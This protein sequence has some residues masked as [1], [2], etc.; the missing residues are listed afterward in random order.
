M[1]GIVQSTAWR[2]KESIL[3]IF[4]QYQVV[5]Y[6]CTSLPVLPLSAGESTGGDIGAF[7][8]GRRYSGEDLTVD[9]PSGTDVCDISTLTIWCEDFDAFFTRITIPA[10]TFVSC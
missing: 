4:I 1:L 6:H 9:L 10:A 7:R 2:L 3:L 5:A 8:Q